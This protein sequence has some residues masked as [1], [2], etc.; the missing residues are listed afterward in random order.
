MSL[1]QLAGVCTYEE[2]AQ[3]GLSVEETVGFMIR[4]AWIKKRMMETSLYWLNPTP[5][6]E[7]KEALSLHIYQDTEHIKLLRNRVTEMRNPPPRMDVSPDQAL[8]N[9]YEELLTAETTIE[10]I[11]GLYG[12]LRESLL[13]ALNEHYHR[14]NPLVDHPTRRILRFIML[15]E[16]DAVNW[17][18][19]AISVLSNASNFAE[20]LQA[21]LAAAG[22]ILGERDRSVE[23]PASRSY[24][25]FMPD[26]F[27]RRDERF[28]Q[29]RNFVFPP[30]E[31]ARTD[32]V[33]ADEK[34][35]ALMCKRTLEMDVPEVIARIIAKAETRDW[36]YYVDMSRQLWDEARH[37]MMGSAY[38]E[39]HGIDWRNEIPLHPGFSIR[40]NK[41]M[42][43]LEAHTVLYAIEQGLMPA[44][45]GKRYEYET[46][47]EANDELAVLFQD[48][49]WADEVLHA[50][51]GRRWLLGMHGLEQDAAIK[52]GGRKAT[53]SESI[54][55]QYANE[56]DQVNW[57]PTF[58]QKIL[59]RKTSMKEFTESL[60]DPVYRKAAGE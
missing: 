28:K 56:E 8:D 1:P 34:T 55:A 60:A 2:A 15:E 52:L 7:V 43:P 54:L 16:E 33:P 21:Y 5:E 6:W 39:E 19:N 11:T 30:H 4:F 26:F 49:D 9:F 17:G 23:L 41:H 10:K 35:L 22:G 12:V 48:F 20:H 37:A 51:I 18:R 40:L 53:E 59:G 27:P 46:A 31:V 24:E 44:K 47:I 38:F 29:Q 25:E 42:S 32:G 14:M 3:V 57:W 13:A 58:V 45:T 36:E 50:Q